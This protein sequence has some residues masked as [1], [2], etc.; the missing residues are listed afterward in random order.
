MAAEKSH[1]LQVYKDP[2]LKRTVTRKEK[3]G[4]WV[5]VLG[6]QEKGEWRSDS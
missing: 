3:P 1:G 2:R 5:L 4:K 6:E